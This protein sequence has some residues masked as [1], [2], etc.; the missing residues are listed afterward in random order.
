[1]DEIFFCPDFYIFGVKIIFFVILRD[2]GSF[3]KVIKIPSKVKFDIFTM[4][5]LSNFI[6]NLIFF[7][8]IRK[9]TQRNFLPG[10][11]GSFFSLDGCIRMAEKHHLANQELKPETAIDGN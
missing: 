1:V 10:T 3:R 7:L 2:L 11:V 6:F 4:E 8:T 9:D 5:N